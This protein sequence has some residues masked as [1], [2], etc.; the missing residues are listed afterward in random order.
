[1]TVD[2]ILITQI[3]YFYKK[4]HEKLLGLLSLKKMALLGCLAWGASLGLG[5]S[6][7]W[8]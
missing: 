7:G 2:R 8:W 5:Y 4:K 6:T 1:M 3:I